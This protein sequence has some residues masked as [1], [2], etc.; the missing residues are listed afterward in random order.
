MSMHLTTF[1]GSVTEAIEKAIQNAIQDA[2][3]EVKGGGGHF[4]ISVRSPLFQGKSKIQSHRLV[5][6]AIKH[7]MSGD[8]APVHAIDSLQTAV[9]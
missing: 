4:Q 8:Q 5:L 6:S 9:P 3:V 1:E 7:L 2:Q